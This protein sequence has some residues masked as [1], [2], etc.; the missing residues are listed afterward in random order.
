MKE[1]ET[2]RGGQK[3]K[4][5]GRKEGG[6]GDEAPQLKFLATPL[7]ATIIINSSSSKVQQTQESYQQESPLL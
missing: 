7:T 1:R 6:K 5:K 3:G 4:K 2:K